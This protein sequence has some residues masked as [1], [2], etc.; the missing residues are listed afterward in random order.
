M[1]EFLRLPL[2]V[3]SCLTNEIVWRGRRHRIDPDCTTTI[4]AENAGEWIE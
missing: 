1:L 3:Y 4:V 2:L